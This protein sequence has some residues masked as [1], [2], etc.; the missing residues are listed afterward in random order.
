MRKRT[1]IMGAGLVLAALTV[2]AYAGPPLICHPFAIGDARSLPWNESGA[3][4]GWNKPL[5]G[6]DTRHLADDTLTLL[7][8]DMPVIARM[9]TLRRAAIYGTGDAKAGKELLARLQ[10]RAE[11]DGKGASAVHL[12]DYGYF[13][14]T[15]R[16]A[17]TADGQRNTA[18]VEGLKGYPYIQE[19]LRRRADDP[20]MEFAAAIVTL[21]PK[22]PAQPDHLR[23]AASGA[24][25]DALLAQN[26]KS[27]FPEQ[28]LALER[29]GKNDK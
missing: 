26:L 5:K 28:R 24:H 10:A 3:E 16:Q 19:A 22:H 12:F 14:E 13:I 23:K 9:E 17:P 2:T 11:K 29:G 6:Y 25:R 15:I 18:P 27:H 8:P 7:T 20:A 1:S 21:S 4:Q